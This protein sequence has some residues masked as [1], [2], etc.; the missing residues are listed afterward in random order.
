MHHTS[1][2]S[3]GCISEHIT[4]ITRRRSAVNFIPSHFIQY[5]R[6]P[7]TRWRAQNLGSRATAAAAVKAKPLSLWGHKPQSTGPQPATTTEIPHYLNLLPWN[8]HIKEFHNS[9]RNHCVFIQ[10]YGEEIRIFHTTKSATK[11]AK[12]CTSVRIITK[13][14]ITKLYNL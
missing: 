9:E 7:S 12:Y 1:K 3:C 10:T 2:T 4:H 14:F 11:T 8:I 13:R 6:A 5:K